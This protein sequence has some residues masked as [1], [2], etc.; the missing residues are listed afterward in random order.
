MKEKPRRKSIG[1]SAAVAAI[2]VAP[3][4]AEDDYNSGHLYGE[5][6]HFRQDNFA[7]GNYRDYFERDFYGYRVRNKE[8]YKGCV[9]DIT[10]ATPRPFKVVSGVK[11]RLSMNVFNRVM[12]NSKVK[13]AA[14][15]SG[16]LFE[17]GNGGLR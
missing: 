2:A 12:Q 5:R 7:D 11:C 15:R 1:L 13:P 4:V 8:G 16:G 3:L 14:A 6:V 10:Y 9:A 17:T